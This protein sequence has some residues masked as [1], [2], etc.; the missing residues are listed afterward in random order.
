MK[1]RARGETKQKEKY[2]KKD[3]LLEKRRKKKGITSFHGQNIK[4]KLNF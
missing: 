2:Y 1:Q 3:T 4:M